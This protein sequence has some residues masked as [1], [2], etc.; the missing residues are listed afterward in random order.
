MI[1]TLATSRSTCA[2][3]IMLAPLQLLAKGHLIS[4]AIGF[5]LRPIYIDL[6]TPDHAQF[7]ANLQNLIE[8]YLDVLQPVFAKITDCAKIGFL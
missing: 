6:A 3:G 2:Y 1:F 7:P 4:A 8:N 5:Q